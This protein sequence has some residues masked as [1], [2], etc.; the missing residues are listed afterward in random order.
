[1]TPRQVQESVAAGAVVLDLR[2]PRP[3]ASG[4]LPGAVN[5][6]FN[7]ADLAE[8]AGM[9]L[10]TGRTYVVH[11]EPDAVARAAA[12]ILERAGFRVAGVLE[13]GLRAWREAGLPV[14][15]L[16]VIDVD[17]LRR[18]RDGYL[19]I[20][21]REPFEY[22]HG[23]IE[24]AVLLPSGEAWRRAEETE[25]GRP[26][27]VVCADQVRSSLVASILKRQGRDAVLVMGGMVDW[28]ERGY[29]VARG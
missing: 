19:V 3:F 10:P 14:E 28:L 1:M 17:Q 13:G 29:P 20:D 11:A 8:R 15:A 6:Q 22:R 5:L 18:A 25:A 16:P 23:H 4:H 26:L 21:A 2:P 7:R 24:D 9:V 12:E 27:A